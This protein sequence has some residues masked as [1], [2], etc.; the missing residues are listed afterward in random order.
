MSVWDLIFSVIALLIIICVWIS[1]FDTNRFVTKAYTVKSGKINECARIIFI[2]DLHNKKY[3]KDNVK[4]INHIKG[5]APDYIFIGGDMINAVP[6]RNADVAVS[7]ITA[8]SKD[9][10]VYYAF[11][12]HEYRLKLYPENY[13]DMYETYFKEINKT[14]TEVLD[15]KDAILD[16][17]NVRLYGLS[18]NRRFYKRFTPTQSMDSNYIDSEIGKACEDYFNIVLAH[19]PEYFESY[20]L[21]GADLTLSGHVHGGVVRVP[22]WGKGMV[23]PRLSLFPKYDG[24]LFEHN[25]HTM[26]VSRGLGTHTL[27]IRVF[28]PGELVVIDLENE[29]SN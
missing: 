19:N 20:A 8:L 9:Y 15:N 14:Q 23:S 29:S 22:F 2:S 28:N 26:I 6:D 27:P 18:I 3:G 25:G 10:P 1:L 24:G 21:W 13:K 7:F 16:E 17:L 5:L 11:G 12:N 4:L